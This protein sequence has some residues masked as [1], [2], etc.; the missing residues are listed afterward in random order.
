MMML[1]TLRHT[2]IYTITEVHEIGFAITELHVIGLLLQSD[3][4]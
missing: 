4:R 2:V 3:K 1:Y